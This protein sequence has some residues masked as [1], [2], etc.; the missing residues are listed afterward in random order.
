MMAFEGSEGLLGLLGTGQ[1]EA[2]WTEEA[3]GIL[4]GQ[5]CPTSLFPQHLARRLL[6]FLNQLSV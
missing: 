6:M 2:C 4:C 1:D 5:V 3:E